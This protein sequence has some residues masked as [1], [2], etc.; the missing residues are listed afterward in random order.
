VNNSSN[1]PCS[2][3]S[4]MFYAVALQSAQPKP[5]TLSSY[6]SSFGKNVRKYAEVGFQRLVVAMPSKL[7][8]EELEEYVQLVTKLCEKCQVRAV[9]LCSVFTV[10]ITSFRVGIQILDTWYSFIKNAHA[11]E[12]A[13]SRTQV[14][15]KH[16]YA[17]SSLPEGTA[18]GEGTKDAETTAGS[19]MQDDVVAVTA[20]MAAG[21]G[22]PVSTPGTPAPTTMQSKIEVSLRGTV[23]FLVFGVMCGSVYV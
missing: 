4:L 11:Q 10:C 21:A 18:S 23:P 20:A 3:S 13:H 15:D 19:A 12:S 7:S 5:A 6:V 1:S 14:S 16:S 17:S 22:T 2:H 8:A 9:F